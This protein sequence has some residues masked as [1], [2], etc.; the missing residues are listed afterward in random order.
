MSAL[1]AQSVSTTI[2]RAVVMVVVL[3][4]ASVLV[5]SVVQKQREIGILRAMGVFL[6]QG[7]LVGLLGAVLGLLLAAGMIELF[8]RFVKGSDGLPLFSI[9]LSPRVALLAGAAGVL[10]ALAPARRAAAAPARRAQELQRRPAER[11]RSAA[12]HRPGAGAR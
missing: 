12:R 9:V 10:A 2:I 7:A 1:N 4:I 11:G 3:G 8:T 5:V 6:V